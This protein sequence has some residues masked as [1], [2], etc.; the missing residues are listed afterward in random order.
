MQE[1]KILNRAETPPIYIDDE[2]HESEA[3]RLKYRYL[4]LR[5]P[6]LQRPWRCAAGDE[7][8]A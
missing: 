4:D 1:A 3:L 6:K 5:K 2:A 7:R 8:C